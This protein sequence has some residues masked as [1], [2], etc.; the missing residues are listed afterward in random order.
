MLYQMDDAAVIKR[1]PDA[2]SGC[3]DRRQSPAGRRAHSRL[4]PVQRRETRLL[5][6]VRAEIVRRKPALEARLARAPLAVEHGEPGGVA[7]AALDDLML[8]EHA[9][10]GEA[11][12]RR[13]APR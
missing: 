5:L 6:A 11:E 9:L 1:L 4:R 12:A 8:A 10:E 7:V 13:R 2:P 3:R